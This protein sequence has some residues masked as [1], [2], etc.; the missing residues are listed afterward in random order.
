M[1][2]KQLG[3][4]TTM[5]ERTLRPELLESNAKSAILGAQTLSKSARTSPPPS[6]KTPVEAVNQKAST[7]P[8]Q[9]KSPV[10]PKAVRPAGNLVTHTGIRPGQTMVPIHTVD[11][12]IKSF[13]GNVRSMY[14][15]R[16]L[17]AFG[18]GFAPTIFRQ[19]TYSTV[20]FTTYNAVK[21]AIHLNSNEPMPSYMALIAGFVSGVA[22]VVATQPIDFVKTRMQSINARA[23]YRSTPRT[24]YKVFIEEGF[25]TFWVGSLPRFFKI[26]GGSAVTFTL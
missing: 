2:T 25:S 4:K 19:L 24:I 3:I 8:S 14:A 22:V 15:E 7:N 1:L 12:S 17:R 20:Q 11:P 6:R 10:R 9:K 13:Y 26:V 18:Q 16:G 21:Q 5:I 23:V